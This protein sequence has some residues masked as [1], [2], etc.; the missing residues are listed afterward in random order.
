MKKQIISTGILLLSAVGAIAQSEYDAL[1]FSQTYQQG[2]ARSAAM[3]GAFGALGGDLSVIANNPA[4]MSIYSTGEVGLTLDVISNNTKSMLN[5]TEKEDSKF[6]MKF[7]NIGCVVANDNGKTSGFNHFAWGVAFNKLND[8]GSHELMGAYNYNSSYLDVWAESANGNTPK[9]LNDYNTG[10]LYDAQVIVEEPEGSGSYIH[11][12]NR[13]WSDTS[14]GAYGE[15]QK[16]TVNQKGGI[17]SWDFG[18]SGAFNNMFYFGASVG[19]QSVNYK[20]T[21]TYSEDDKDNITAYEY[22]DYSEKIRT[23][24]TGVNLKLGLLVK[25]INFIRLGAAFHTPTVYSMSDEHYSTVETLFDNGFTDERES[26]RIDY[27]YQLSTPMKGI[28]S[29]AFIVPGYGLI[30]FDYESVNYGKC[31]FHNADWDEADFD[32]ENDAIVEKFQKTNNFRV[33]AEGLAGPVSIRA[34]YALYGNPLKEYKGNKERQIL[35]LGFGFKGD[36]IYFD[37]TGTYH[38]YQ[39]DAVLYE[40]RSVTQMYSYDNRYLNVLATFGVRF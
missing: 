35:S 15:Y 28:L 26:P 13:Q 18:F 10:I 16:R 1:R 14:T 22:W 30:S 34:G 19:V 37:I 20:Y 24:G 12:H 8:F 36:D 6:A 32:V 40:S 5:G 21:G 7:S 17:N 11:P 38:I 33:G 39:K 9:K 29:A 31:K 25:P 3:G 2:T 4:G 23:H 27:D